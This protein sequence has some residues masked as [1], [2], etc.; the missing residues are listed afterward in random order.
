ME[1]QKYTLVSFIPG[2]LCQLQI[3]F[4]QH[5]KLVANAAP[6]MYFPD[7]FRLQGLFCGSSPGIQSHR[8]IYLLHTVP[9]AEY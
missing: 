3:T 5:G 4:W 1:I 8:G 7:M 9:L 2:F 6:S